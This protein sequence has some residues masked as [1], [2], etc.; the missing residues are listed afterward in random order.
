MLR[1]GAAALAAAV[2]VVVELRSTNADAAFAAEP[3]VWVL[4]EPDEDCNA[5]CR[6]RGRAC[7]ESAFAAVVTEDATRAIAIAG[8][9]PSIAIATRAAGDGPRNGS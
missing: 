4:G 7:S 6:R 2:V 3:N 8:G 9:Q 1:A 5:V